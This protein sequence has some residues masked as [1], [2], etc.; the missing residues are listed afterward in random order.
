MALRILCID[1]EPET[2]AGLKGSGLIAVAAE[3]G[4]RSGK[5]RFGTPPHEY[6]L[7]V[8][9]LRKP[10]C[11][12]SQDWGPGRND[13]F[14]CKLVDTLSDQAYLRNGELRY[15]HTI[16]QEGQL[17]AIIPGTFGP[18]NVL[19]AISD[20]GVPF[21]LLLNDEW[22]KRVAYWFP[23]FFNLSWHF[24]R[25]VATQIKI[26]PILSDRIAGLGTTIK[27]SLP[28]RNAIADRPKG[29]T[30]A[31]YSSLT[32]FPLVTNAVKD[33]FGQVVSVGSGNIWL[34]PPFEDSVLAICSIA[35]NLSSFKEPIT[36][37]L[38][39]G[40]V[41][42]VPTT[43]EASGQAQK[44]TA[45]A[46]SATYAS[47]GVKAPAPGADSDSR[48]VFVVHG[49]DERLRTGIFDF[50]RSLDLRPLEWTEAIKLT[51]K[52]S[53][54]VGEI[55]D[56]AFSNARA[57]V[58]LFTPDDEARLR[59]ELRAAT[60]PSYETNL[61]PQ[62][63]PNV[64]FEAGMAMGRDPDHTI[65]VQ[66]GES[67]PFSDI[68]GRHTIRM[69]NSTSKR[70]DLALRLREAGCNVNLEGTDWH[71]AGDLSTTNK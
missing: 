43:F 45:S 49:R 64:L 22:V 50:L 17:P 9:D 38:S 15:K 14:H 21:F 29:R 36:T 25:T 46:S 24:R 10:A 42:P 5:R 31:S 34:L 27:I 57:V 48:T 41:I 56:A 63:R 13:N 62:A 32:S 6:D 68:A 12:D 44:A 2:V 30:G 7:M 26:D 40:A 52:A 51:G 37:R 61:T 69:D 19:Q 18:G 16:I 39:G 55:L 4:Y 67:R 1:C 23:N 33:V 71:K 54:Y 47:V 3:L 53:P 66:I 28:L 11:F 20:G 70:Q 35:S 59:V 65:F 58:V 60:D 8:C